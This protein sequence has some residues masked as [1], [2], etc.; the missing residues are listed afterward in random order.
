[1]TFAERDEIKIHTGLIALGGYR[2]GKYWWFLTEDHQHVKYWPKT[3]VSEVL[4]MNDRE[5]TVLC[6]ER[7]PHEEISITEP[8]GCHWCG[9]PYR[10]HVRQYRYPIGWHKWLQPNQEQILSRMKARRA[11][12]LTGQ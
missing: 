9:I 3:Q 7:F 12:R 1:M 8:M 2:Y 4:P 6:L 5:H 11:K 10:S